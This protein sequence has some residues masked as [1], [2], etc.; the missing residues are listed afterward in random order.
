M[1]D[2]DL[3]DLG[4]Q[5][6]CKNCGTEGLHWINFKG[7]WYLFNENSQRHVCEQRK[8]SAAEAFQRYFQK[9]RK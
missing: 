4:P 7:K 5:V 1:Q 3:N 2:E 8:Q 9:Q 6:T